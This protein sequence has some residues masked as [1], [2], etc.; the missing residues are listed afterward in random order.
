MNYNLIHKTINFVYENIYIY[1]IKQHSFNRIN[2][3]IGSL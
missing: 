1:D 2:V 3:L